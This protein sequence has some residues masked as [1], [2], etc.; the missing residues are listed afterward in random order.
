MSINLLRRTGDSAPRASG[1]ADELGDGSASAGVE[2]GQRVPPRRTLTNRAPGIRS[3]IAA[4]PCRAPACRPRRRRR[5]SAPRATRTDRSRCRGCRCSRRRSSRARGPTGNRPSTI[6]RS[7][8][9]SRSSGTNPAGVPDM[10][11]RRERASRRIAQN[12]G[13]LKRIGASSRGGPERRL[14]GAARS[15]RSRPAARRAPDAAARAGPPTSCPPRTPPPAARRS[16]GDPAAPRTHQPARQAKD[17][18]AA[19]T[20][21]SRTA[22]AR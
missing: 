9:R 19:A 17:P 8:A 1:S 5:A 7:A 18:A 13:W 2:L 10:P 20:Q 3:A 14:R 12:T 21:K 4:S 11:S 15:A 22:T 16:P 6:S